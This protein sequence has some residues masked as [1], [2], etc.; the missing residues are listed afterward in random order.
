[1]IVSND[2]A[3]IA[4]IAQQGG[5]IAYPTQAVFGLGCRADKLDSIQKLLTLKQRPASKGLILLAS[6]LTQLAHYILPLSTTQQTQ[7]QQSHRA[8]TWLV[9]AQPNISTLLT[10]QHKNI[11]IRITQHPPTRALCQLINHPITSTSANL[12]GQKPA[13]IQQEI[14]DF[15]KHDINGL[16]NH[17]TGHAK[18]PSQIIDL[19]TGRILRS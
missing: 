9:P 7:I 4:N 16:L 3:I 1:M 13:I 5:I 17:P 10:G 18:Q 15:F 8:T 14:I 19:M 6:N 11:A 2:T 12:N